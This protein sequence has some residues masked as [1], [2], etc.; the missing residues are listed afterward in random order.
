MQEDKKRKAAE[1]EK[2]RKEEEAAAKES[3]GGKKEYKKGME[4]WYDN[5][6]DWVEAV[7]VKMGDLLTLE[8][9]E[10]G[11]QVADVEHD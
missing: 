11:E 10:T 1:E 4:V 3:G 9:R 6:E 7:I 2:K 5:G 8:L